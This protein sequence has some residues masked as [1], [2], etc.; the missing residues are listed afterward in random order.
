MKLA[1][2]FA[3]PK[4]WSLLAV[5]VACAAGVVLRI[6]K[7]HGTPSDRPLAIVVS[8]DTAGW[9]IPCGCTTNQSGG[10]ARRATYIKQLAV[11][12]DVIV[13]DAGGAAGGD[14]AYD[15]L[16]FA[17][18]LSGEETMGLAAHNLGGSE[19]SLGADECRRSADSGAPLISANTTDRGGKPIVAPL[20]IVAAGGR[21]I[22]L[23]GVVSPHYATAE[24]QVAPPGAA[25]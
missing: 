1:G 18:I 14:S 15:G 2:G 9:I 23:V 3:R 16:K 20:R 12:S 10:L 8:A 17:A 21:R 19:L 6:G 25:C 24:I 7:G 13:A 5:A 22:A 4:R 11:D